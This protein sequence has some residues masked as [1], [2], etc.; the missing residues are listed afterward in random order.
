MH[1]RIALVAATLAVFAVAGA[2]GQPAAVN[3]DA[4]A[5]A[6]E[7]PIAENFVNPTPHPFNGSADGLKK[8]RIRRDI[9]IFQI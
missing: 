2:R 1:D 8:V 4:A 7:K 5:T 9:S 6:S 3:I